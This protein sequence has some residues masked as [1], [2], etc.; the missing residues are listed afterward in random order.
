MALG[1]VRIGGNLE[2]ALLQAEKGVGIAAQSGERRRRGSHWYPA[3][4]E[5]FSLPWHFLE[6]FAN[7]SFNSLLRCMHGHI[8]MGRIAVSL[9][10]NLF[11][12]GLCRPH[13]PVP[14]RPSGHG[15]VSPAA[16]APAKA[17][18][19]QKADELRNSHSVHCCITYSSLGRRSC[20]VLLSSPEEWQISFTHYQ[21][22]EEPAS[23]AEKSD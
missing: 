10:V 11:S 2:V 18:S 6:N 14:D 1:N 17:D 15:T 5:T 19:R 20:G 23:R 22:A 8:S 7:T 16:S 21:L 12:I 3:S 9:D 4:A 13:L